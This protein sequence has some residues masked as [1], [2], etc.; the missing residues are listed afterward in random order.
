MLL[1]STPIQSKY[2]DWQKD[3]GS[4]V[5]EMS[6]LRCVYPHFN[7]FKQIYDDA[8]DQGFSIQST[9][10]GEIIT[11]YHDRTDMSDSGEDTYGWVFKPIPEHARKNPKL[12]NLEVLIIND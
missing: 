9:K 12:K 10:T 1:P 6:T 5:Q 3:T 2:F 8:C 7:F 4:L 11:V